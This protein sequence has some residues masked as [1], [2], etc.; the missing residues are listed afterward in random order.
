MPKASN[1]EQDLRVS[2]VYE[3]IVQGMPTRAILQF[4]AGKWGIRTRAG[5][6]LIAKARQELVKNASVDRE[7]SL[8]EEI[9]ARREL[10][11][12]SLESGKLQTALNAMDSR[13]K[14]RGLFNKE[15][16]QNSTEV[17]NIVGTGFET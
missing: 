14:L 12:L 7:F 5:E 4:C 2:E 6:Y 11:K 15:D 16:P 9:E 8:A 10:I 3:Q 1:H 17:I 13:A